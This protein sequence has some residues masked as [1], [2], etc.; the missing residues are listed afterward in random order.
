M[1][2]SV[3]AMARAKQVT[4]KSSPSLRPLWQV[5]L[6]L[7]LICA[8]L[9]GWTL[10][11]PMVFDDITYLKMNP[12]FRAESFD[13]PTRFIEFAT[14]PQ[15]NGLDPDLAVN[16]I[17][18]PVAYGSFYLNY[19]WQGYE[20]QTYRLWNIVIHLL[21]GLLM[22]QLMNLLLKRFV[23]TSQVSKASA[24]F[25]PLALALLFIVHPLA[26]ESVTYIVQ[27]FTSLAAMFGLLVLCLHVASLGAISPRTKWLLRGCAVLVM[28]LGM[29]T[30][31]CS[32]VIPLFAVMLDWLVLRSALRVAIMRALPLLCCLPLIPALVLLTSAALSDGALDLAAGLNIV[33]NRD[34]PLPHWHYLLTQLTVVAHYLRLMLWPSGLNLDPSWPIHERFFTLPVLVSAGL[35]LVILTA[36]GFGFRRF[37]EDVRSRLIWFGVLWFYLGISISSGLVP[38]PDMVAEHRTYLPSVGFYLVI[39]GVLDVLRQRLASSRSFR[40]Q[41][42][43]FKTGW[44]LCLLAL[45][46]ATCQRNEVWRTGVSLWRDTAL[47]SP[48][49]YRPWSNLGAELSLL[50][51]EVE[52]VECFEKSVAIEPAFHIGVLNLS[53]S[54]LRL[55]RP[56]ESLSAMQKLVESSEP[57]AKDPA[58]VYTMGLCL[59]SV[60]RHHEAAAKL[61]SLLARPV[62]D[63]NIHKVLGLIYTKT[64]DLKRALA[65]YEHALKLSP[66]D[67]KAQAMIQKLESALR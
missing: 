42:A 67:Q 53:N 28:L 32:V 59:T 3:S 11:F 50:G 64:Q 44:A 12:L 20:P 49:K 9:Y 21:N 14:W 27:R 8:A 13:Y 26:V 15:K 24:L 61:E 17:T 40:L 57:A 41:Q 62:S 29:L 65:H 63:P 48:E 4:Q 19:L 37:Q 18:R 16:F 60:G 43:A 34:K 36:A 56:Q 22:F 1:E 33:N 6:W 58:V 45:A 10:G 52:A 55:K 30:K 46:V 51:K 25:M 2:K 66:Q 47:K 5:V 31:E 7:S 38:L 39:I 54:L 23:A 35:H